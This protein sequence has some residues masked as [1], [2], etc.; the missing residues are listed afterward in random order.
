MPHGVIVV[1]T[2]KPTPVTEA[3]RSPARPGGTARTKMS[4]R[5]IQV[6]PTTA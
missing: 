2:T 1:T 6:V 4:A 5:W 3:S